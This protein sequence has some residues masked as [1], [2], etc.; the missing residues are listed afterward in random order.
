MPESSVLHKGYAAVGKNTQIIAPQ[1]TLVTPV[2]N[3]RIQAFFD[4]VGVKKLPE[5]VV[6]VPAKN[7][8]QVSETMSQKDTNWAFTAG[9]RVYLNDA[10]FDQKHPNSHYNGPEFPEFLLGHELAH[11]NDSTTPFWMQ[12]RL[13]DQSWHQGTGNPYDQKSED[14]LNRWQKQGGPAY[15]ALKQQAPATIGSARPTPVPLRN[16]VSP[17]APLLGRIP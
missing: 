5:A 16:L 3:A 15:S 14:Y 13:E 4:T 11:L 7:F 17:Q 8:K 9:N 2:Q 1:G 6:L 12:E 10:A